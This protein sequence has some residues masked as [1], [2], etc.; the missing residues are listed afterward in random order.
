MY[1]NNFTTCPICQRVFNSKQGLVN[2]LN[3]SHKTKLE[4]VII[5]YELNNIQPT[6]KC[7]CGTPVHLVKYQFKTWIRG[8]ISR[9]KNNWGHNQIAIDNSSKRRR[10]QFKNGERTTWC[11]GIKGEEYIKHFNRLDGTNSLLEMH[12]N[13]ERNEKISKKLTG[14]KR[15]PEMVAKQKALWTPEKRHQQG[16]IRSEHIK[17]FG[18]LTPSKL[19]QRFKIILDEL[20]IKYTEQYRIPNFGSIYDFYLPDFHILIETDGDFYHCNPI[21]YPIPIHSLQVAN[22]KNDLKKNKIA[23]D[24]GYILLR[25]WDSE[26]TNNKDSVIDI[27]LRAIDN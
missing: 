26:I 5:Q 8:H 25:F 15:T 12:K 17:K 2:H 11:K 21:K 18:W 1:L 7:G 27:L 14:M 3:H 22:I 16:L 6:C 23:Q 9:V 10:E 19:E 13:P 20:Q 24:N 4:P